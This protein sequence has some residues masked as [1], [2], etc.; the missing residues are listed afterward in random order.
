MKNEITSFK[1]NDLIEFIDI[2]CLSDEELKKLNGLELLTS[3][4]KEN[5]IEWCNKIK[6]P[7]K[8]EKYNELITSHKNE[9]ELRKKLE[10]DDRAQNRIGLVYLSNMQPRRSKS[11]VPIDVSDKQLDRA[12]RIINTIIEALKDLNGD[13]TTTWSEEDNAEVRLLGCTFAFEVLELKKK[14]RAF[15]KNELGGANKKSFRP[16]YERIYSG[17]LIVQFTEV[18][19][20]F[21]KEKLTDNVLKFSDLSERSLEDSMP[22]IFKEL[23][24]AVL[25]ININKIMATR[26]ENLKREQEELVRKK[27]EEAKKSLERAEKKKVLLNELIDNIENQM[28]IWFKVQNLTKYADE[29][30]EF[31]LTLEDG[32]E[33]K[34]LTTYVELVRKKAKD[35]NPVPDIIS[36]V[37]VLDI[38]D[39]LVR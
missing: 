36:R 13:L 16:A 19:H 1:Q 29:L 5:F 34:S 2:K 12:Y 32:E 7:K 20:E 31:L 26:K 37:E 14:R 6:V 15:D 18:V 11:V 21:G 4:S 38:Q 25:S 24:S 33:K 22:E 30:E 10:E 3:R 27:S 8:F 28:D 17:E 35:I 23:L 39:I 9:I